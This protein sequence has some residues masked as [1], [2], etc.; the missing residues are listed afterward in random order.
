MLADNDRLLDTVEQVLQ[1]SRSG[2]KATE[3]HRTEFDI[4]EL[5]GE[6]IQT[7]LLRRHLDESA[8]R[9][10]FPSEPVEISADREE[11]TTVFS[12]LLD[13]A[14]KYS[15]EGPRLSVRIARRMR[16]VDVF[17]QDSGI[18]ISRAD[19]KRVFKRF[20]R[21][22][23][24]AAAAA[25]GTGLGL[26]IVRSIVERHGGRVTADSAGLGKGSTF[27]VRLPL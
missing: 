15:P 8:I 9:T 7:T 4:R 16:S 23:D 3:L 1:A 5:M 2:E 13:N 24:K 18:G 12:N 14:I 11:L 27:I 10:T 20:Y 21:S 17:V 26:A 6:V 22:R 25:K 19:L